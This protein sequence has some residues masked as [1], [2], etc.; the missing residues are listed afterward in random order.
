M[1]RLAKTE[2]TWGARA[3]CTF[4]SRAAP[5]RPF[6]TAIYLL[7]FKS[8]QFYLYSAFSKQIWMKMLSR[9]SLSLWAAENTLFNIADVWNMALTRLMFHTRDAQ[10]DRSSKVFNR[11]Q[12]LNLNS[13]SLNAS[14]LSPKFHVI[15][16]P[17]H[18][19][20]TP[21]FFCFLSFTCS[22][23]RSSLLLACYRLH[24][25]F[26]WEL[27]EASNLFAEVFSLTP[28]NGFSLPV[29]VLE[30]P[31]RGRLACGSN[32]R[33]CV[34]VLTFPLKINSSMSAPTSKYY[35]ITSNFPDN[36]IWSPLIITS[37]GFRCYFPD[38]N[39]WN[40]LIILPPIKW[41]TVSTS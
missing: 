36:N 21:S 12:F 1:S 26:W 13:K 38:N 25:F 7:Y 17:R 2:S 40:P 35:L 5:K 14:T 6:T 4:T 39:I 18:A 31:G 41:S 32:M 22:A 10:K 20:S 33:F 23:L 16:K 28:P 3:G 27:T 24:L 11:K 30:V 15:T 9:M 8:S 37:G 19:P 34:T 29:W